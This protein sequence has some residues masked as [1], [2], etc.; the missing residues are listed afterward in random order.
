M[1][2]I[3]AALARLRAEFLEMPGLGLTASQVQRLCG[4]EKAMCDAVLETLVGV[5]FLRVGS[6]GVYRRLTEGALARPTTVKADL[7]PA[8]PVTRAS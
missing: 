8:P 6:D 3:A 7:R 4:I 2:A 5:K 1:S